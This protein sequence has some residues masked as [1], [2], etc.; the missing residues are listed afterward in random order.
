MVKEENGSTRSTTRGPGR[1]ETPAL[2]PSKPPIRDEEGLVEV[3]WEGDLEDELSSLET[4]P[5]DATSFSA[6]ESPPTE[7]LIEDRYAAIQAL[8]ERDTWL[9]NGEPAMDTHDRSTDYAAEL[10]DTAEATA[11]GQSSAGS[12][13]SGG[14][15]SRGPARIRPLQPALHAVPPVEVAAN[16]WIRP[17]RIGAGTPHGSRKR[18]TRGND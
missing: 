13:A 8:S 11:S 2:V 16:R 15:S 14:I 18:K 1:A 6:H 17:L 5:S 12:S 10:A 9:T 3:G 4:A 7:E